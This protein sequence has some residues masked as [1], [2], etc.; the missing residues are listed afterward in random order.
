LDVHE[1]APAVGRSIR[2]ATKI[3]VHMVEAIHVDNCE[4][5]QTRL[6]AQTHFI[7][8]MANIQAKT[9]LKEATWLEASV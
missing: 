2:A 3:Y 4:Q 5:A 8:N 6:E 9:E 1:L 7:A